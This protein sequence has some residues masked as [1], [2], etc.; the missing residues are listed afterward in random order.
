MRRH[1]L[2]STTARAGLLAFRATPRVLPLGVMPALLV[3][4]AYLCFASTP[5]P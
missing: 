2:R 1:R 3:L 4:A 5:A